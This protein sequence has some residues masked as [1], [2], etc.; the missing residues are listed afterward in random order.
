MAALGMGVQYGVLMP[1]S[2]AH[3]TEADVLGFTVNDDR[4]FNPQSPL[5]FWHGMAPTVKVMLRWK[6]LSTHPSDQTRI[7]QLQSLV[8]QVQPMYQ[9][10]LAGGVHPQCAG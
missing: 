8:P 9:Q 5:I 10:A 1:Y 4:G 3:E 6:S 2:R 7:N